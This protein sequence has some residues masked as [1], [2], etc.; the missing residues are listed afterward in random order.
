MKEQIKT[1]QIVLFGRRREV[2][3]ALLRGDRN[4]V[5]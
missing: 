1:G 4:M 3:T 5:V 2:D